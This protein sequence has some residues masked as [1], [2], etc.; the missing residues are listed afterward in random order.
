MRKNSFKALRAMVHG[1]Y[2]DMLIGRF[3]SEY[4]W[5]SGGAGVKNN[6]HLCTISLI[7]ILLL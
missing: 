2:T 6:T 5:I 4:V 7:T 1:S 3:I